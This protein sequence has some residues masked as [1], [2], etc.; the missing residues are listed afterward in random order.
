MSTTF[1]D[2]SVRY[3][4]SLITH[5]CTPLPGVLPR[6][7]RLKARLFS[8]FVSLP[9]CTTADTAVARVKSL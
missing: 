9:C 3:L 2:S 5:F 8:Y 7:S 6:L 1:L 4:H